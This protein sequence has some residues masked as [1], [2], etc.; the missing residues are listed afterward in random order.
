MV[1]ATLILTAV[2]VAYGLPR[3]LLDLSELRERQRA[4]RRQ[5]RPRRRR[6]LDI[7][8]R[9]RLRIKRR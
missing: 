6:S 2:L 5:R 9:F 7:E 1:L 8:L 3:F 4:R